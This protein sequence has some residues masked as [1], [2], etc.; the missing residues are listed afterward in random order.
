MKCLPLII[1]MIICASV[2]VNGYNYNVTFL[3]ATTSVPNIGKCGNTFIQELHDSQNQV[4]K[5]YET[6]G[7]C[8][9]FNRLKDCIVGHVPDKCGDN[10]MRQLVDPFVETA[11]QI[12]TPSGDCRDYRSFP[13]LWALCQPDWL[14]IVEAIGLAILFLGMVSAVV[15]DLQA[16]LSSHFSHHFL[17][18]Y[19][20][21]VITKTVFTT[22]TLTMK[23]SPLII[24]M[25]IC[26]PIAVKMVKPVPPK[27]Q[28]TTG[29]GVDIGKC[30][31]TFSQDLRHS[32]NQVLR[33][34]VTRGY[35]CAFN[36]LKDYISTP[37]GDC[38]DY[39]G[40]QRTVLCQPDWLLIVG[41]IGLAIISLAIVS[42]VVILCWVPCGAILIIILMIVFLV[43]LLC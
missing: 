28:C 5:N 42:A 38:D 22:R 10:E 7:Y 35:C 12:M 41:A 29:H 40:L 13:G 6:R 36:D 26:A 17:H 18:T 3:C 21:N 43:I 2:A 11:K 39:Q 9:A 15:R 20:H 23:C 1:P 30:V 25:I 33:D 27:V 24:A 31:D 34:Y 32:K 16:L 4:L 8:C 14:L 19:H 37:S